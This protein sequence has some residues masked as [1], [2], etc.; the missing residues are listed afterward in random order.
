M[1]LFYPHFD[2]CCEIHT[3]QV[4]NAYLYN[5]LLELLHTMTIYLANINE[6]FVKLC[7]LKLKNIFAYNSYLLAFTGFRTVLES[8]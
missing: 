5:K 1:C 8:L 3:R 7:A 2:Y 4:H 6:I